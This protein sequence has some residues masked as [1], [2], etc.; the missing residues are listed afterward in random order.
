MAYGLLS[1]ISAHPGKGGDLADHLLRA[2]HL[3]E[4]DSGCVQYV[5]STSDEADVV[6]VFEVW[7]DRAAHDASLEPA[8]VRA[9]VRQA[10]PLIARPPEQTRMSVRGGKGVSAE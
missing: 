6:W 2:A 4:R 5:V 7:T 8:D 9:L 10:Q 1:K 3:L